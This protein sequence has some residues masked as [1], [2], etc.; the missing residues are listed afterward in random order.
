MMYSE[1]CTLNPMFLICMGGCSGNIYLLGLLENSLHI[2]FIGPL[3][4]TKH[5]IDNSNYYDC[6]FI[7]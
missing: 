1:W 2:A 3:L 5:Y 4:Y 7:Q 6:L